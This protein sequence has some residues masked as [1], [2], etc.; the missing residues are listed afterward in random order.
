MEAIHPED[1]KQLRTVTDLLSGLSER[2]E[3]AEL[4]GLAYAIGRNRGALEGAERTADYIG[5]FGA[6]A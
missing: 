5:K 2:E 1:T 6:R 4:V 3:I